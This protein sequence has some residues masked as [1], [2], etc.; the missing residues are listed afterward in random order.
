MANP[1]IIDILPFDASN[2]QGIGRIVSAPQD[3]YPVTLDVPFQVTKI[4]NSTSYAYGR[5]V[6]AGVAGNITY[7]KYNGQTAIL[8]NAIA[9]VWHP[10]C[11]LQINTSGTSAQL[12]SWG[13]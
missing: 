7:V 9:G 13:N 12:M 3:V 4:D 1:L 6:W 8:H 5:W 10:I 2:I 11:A